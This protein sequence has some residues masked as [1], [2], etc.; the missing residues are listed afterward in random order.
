MPVLAQDIDA[1]LHAVAPWVDWEH[2][3]DGFKYGDPASEV[4]GIA[5]AW[6]SLQDALEE[7]HELGCNLFVT[8]E[9][10]F[11]SHM[12]DDERLKA[13]EPARR[14]MAFLDHADMVVYRCHDAWDVYPQIG[15][16]D[17]WSRFLGLGEPI[18]RAKYY[19][20][21][22][23]D[24]VS[25]WELT[26]RLA[27]RVASLGEGAVQFVGTKWQMVSRLAVG[28]GAITNVRQ[29]VDLGADVVLVTDDGTTLWRDAAWMEDLGVPMIIVN[30]MTAEIPGLRKLAEHLQERFPQIPVH[31][32]GPTCSYALAATQR[33]AD[34]SIH[35]RRNDLE[36]LPPIELPSGYTA[37]A[38]RE[39]EAWAYLAVMNKSNY[40]G[41]A[42]EIWFERTFS[43][44]PEYDPAFL[45]I[46]WRGEQPVAA[47]AG[48]HAEIEGER[49]GVVHWVG[50][51]SG[52]R[53]RK[54]SRAV[55]LAALHC[56]KARSFGKAMLITQDW[57]M[58]AIATYLRLG[59]KP[60]PNE[61]APEQVWQRVLTNLQ[62]WR[63]WGRRPHWEELS[64][65]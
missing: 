8:H 13:T 25:A 2:T 36:N 65:S 57:R 56:L 23:L 9:P 14:K 34:V 30:H 41:E 55:S 16:V 54:L 11:Y 29:M 52:E 28:T 58:A 37:R 20:L 42:D 47:A 35:M 24:S 53:G 49:W 27:Q 5:V 4:K 32:V 15:I 26:Y 50:V 31:F 33:N 6:Q 18:A 44:D 39:D 63:R 62:S 51:D 19:N 38:M 12:D 10:T 21:H 48:W 60:W 46:I 3:C 40:S 61:T 59:F 7:A 64:P 43:S 45:Q 17:A 22:A 1:H